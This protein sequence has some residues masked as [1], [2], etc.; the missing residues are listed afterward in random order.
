MCQVYTI[1]AFLHLTFETIIWSKHCTSVSL[2]RIKRV[3]LTCQN[4]IFS[5]MVESGFKLRYSDF[6][7]MFLKFWFIFIV[8]W[9]RHSWGFPEVKINKNHLF[10]PKTSQKFFLVLGLGTLT[11]FL[12]HF[13]YLIFSV[14]KLDS[15]LVKW[16]VQNLGPHGIF[17]LLS[18][19]WL[20][21]TF[22]HFY[23][24][25]HDLTLIKIYV[26]PTIPLSLII[27][28]SLM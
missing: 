3:K 15:W 25:Y 27:P 20:H 24:W 7:E 21:Y 19:V 12:P 2:V 22:Q 6:T 10:V 9:I 4:H 17:W 28:F 14:K 18:P 23:S 26:K 11:S 1:H 16:F 8:L 13:P 5:E